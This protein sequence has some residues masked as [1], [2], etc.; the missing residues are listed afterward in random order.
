VTDLADKFLTLELEVS[1]FDHEAH[2]HV[3]FALLR[4]YSF[5]EA[6]TLYA[7]RLVT[8]TRQIGQP[9]KFNLTITLAMMAMIA[10]RMKTTLQDDFD[11][12]IAQNTDLL[13]TKIL[14]HWYSKDRLSSPLARS[15]FLL[16]DIA[17]AS[18]QK[19]VI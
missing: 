6:T 1:E 9:D 16:P 12:F 19:R 14:T 4:R 3:A 15:V 8:I 17:P 2:V 10:E 11:D 18:V 5:V 13:D 7:D